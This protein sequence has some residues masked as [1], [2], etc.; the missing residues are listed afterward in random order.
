MRVAGWCLA[1]E[2][3]QN[4]ADEGVSKLKTGREKRIARQRFTDVLKT[5]AWIPDLRKTST[6]EITIHPVTEQRFY[7]LR[8]RA[9]FGASSPQQTRGRTC[10]T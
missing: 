6:P 3:K 8:L 10:F 2:T 9:D 7:W 1:R 5:A 4:F